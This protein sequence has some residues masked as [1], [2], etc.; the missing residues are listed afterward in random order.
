MAIEIE[1]YPLSSKKGKFLLHQLSQYSDG[2]HRQEVEGIT[3]K[4]LLRSPRFQVEYL[5]EIDQSVRDSQ[6]AKELAL[7]ILYDLLQG[8]IQRR[9]IFNE[10]VLDLFQISGQVEDEEYSLTV[11][12]GA[13]RYVAGVEPHCR[14][15]EVRVVE[16]G[17]KQFGKDYLAALEEMQALQRMNVK[18]IR[19]YLDTLLIYDAEAGLFKKFGVGFVN[20][21]L[22]WGLE[23][24]ISG[25]REVVEGI[26]AEILRQFAQK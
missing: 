6:G 22:D 8:K 20:P 15:G 19:P 2:V 18:I 9:E 21:M 12:T 26:K 24:V 17:K 3:E 1:T 5:K 10:T 11:R 7:K 14:I 23:E 25:E 13:E 4:R 16:K